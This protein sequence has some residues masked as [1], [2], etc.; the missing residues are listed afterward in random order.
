MADVAMAMAAVMPVVSAPEIASAGLWATWER[1]DAHPTSNII[2]PRVMMV[3]I[4]FLISS[5][6]ANIIYL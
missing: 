4:V 3:G 2:H 6:I 1:D 5:P